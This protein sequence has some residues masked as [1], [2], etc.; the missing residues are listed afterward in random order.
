MGD[1][2]SELPAYQVCLE[3]PHESVKYVQYKGQ[4]DI[5]SIMPPLS[6]DSPPPIIFNIT[7][8]VGGGGGRGAH[9]KCT[10][11]FKQVRSKLFHLRKSPK[12]HEICFFMK[13][14]I[15]RYCPFMTDISRRKDLTQKTERHF[16]KI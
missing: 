3:N 2:I 16:R 5:K 1:Y 12:A 9:E 10:L 8:V 4:W 7:E 6:S 15:K 14:N 13:R 11:W